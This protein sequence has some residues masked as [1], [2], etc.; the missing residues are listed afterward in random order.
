MSSYELVKLMSEGDVLVIG[1]A[2]RWADSLRGEAGLAHLA[3]SA[4][5]FVVE[6]TTVR[7]P[8]GRVAPYP[9]A[10][11]RRIHCDLDTAPHLVAQAISLLAPGGRVILCGEK[12]MSPF[13]RTGWAGYLSAAGLIL[14]GESA[15]RELTAR[16]D[17]DDVT[18]DTE[19]VFCARYRFRLNEDAGLPG[20][21]GVLWG[22]DDVWCAPDLAPLRPGH[23]LLVSTAHYPCYGACPTGVL[24]RLAKH[25]ELV[26]RLLTRVYGLPVT[27]F[28]HGPATSQGAGACIDHAHLHCVPGVATVRARVEAE[29]LSGHALGRAG[30]ADFYRRG[31]SYLY[32][33]DAEGPSAYPCTTPLPTQFLRKA[34][35]ELGPWRW[36][37]SYGTLATRERFLLT[38]RGLLPWADRPARGRQDSNQCNSRAV[39]RSPNPMGSEAAW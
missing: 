11:F 32:V 1:G 9:S 7:R 23:L 38:L 13:E 12:P 6:G 36:Q 27:F 20:A 31:T 26:T 29:G 19:C 14:E 37:E 3:T 16:K 17:G 21:A 8:A 28:E 2:P 33:E 22:D 34:A 5:G 35:A 24:G 18:G 10:F 30:P 15:G 4:E 25:K 39:S